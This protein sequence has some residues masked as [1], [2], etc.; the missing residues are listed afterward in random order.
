MKES[1]TVEKQADCAKEAVKWSK[2]FEGVVSVFG[3]A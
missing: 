3:L 1:Q 2:R